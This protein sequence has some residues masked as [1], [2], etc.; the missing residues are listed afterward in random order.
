M[1][2]WFEIAVTILLTLIVIEL[3]G[4]EG[5]IHMVAEAVHKKH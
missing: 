4:I 2:L 5:N 3:F 1:S